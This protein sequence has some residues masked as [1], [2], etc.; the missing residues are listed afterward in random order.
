MLTDA[1]SELME[2]DNEISRLTKEVVELRL[3]KAGNM[4][5]E[6]CE[7]EVDFVEPI[8][9]RSPRFMDVLHE[10]HDTGNVV[11]DGEQNNSTTKAQDNR[12]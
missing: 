1:Q 11:Q 7:N 9:N 12:G 3:L 5:S 2:K 4:A 8:I 6:S 10:E